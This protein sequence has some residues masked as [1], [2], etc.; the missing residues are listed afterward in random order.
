MAR[1]VARLTARVSVGLPLCREE[2]LIQIS[3]GFTRIFA[4]TLFVLRATPDL[5]HPLLAFIL[6]SFYRIAQSLRKVD[7][8]ITPLVRE[9]T[10]VR[11]QGRASDAFKEPCVLPWMM[12]CVDQDDEGKSQVAARLLLMLSV[13]AIHTTA[14]ATVQALHDLAAHPEIVMPLREEVEPYVRVPGRLDQRALTEMRQLDSFMRESQR[15]NPPSVCKLIASFLAHGLPFHS[16]QR[17]RGLPNDH[18]R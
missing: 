5:V 8:L 11:A 6:P 13:A 16:F 2:D 1:L 15:S 9:W 7:E 3:I 18:P 12:E 17:M 4:T 10:Q 14:I